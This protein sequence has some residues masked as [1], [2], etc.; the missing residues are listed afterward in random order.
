MDYNITNSFKNGYNSK[1]YA[2]WILHN[3]NGKMFYNFCSDINY[4]SV[5]FIIHNVFSKYQD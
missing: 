4:I 2:M 3:K 1:F 5:L